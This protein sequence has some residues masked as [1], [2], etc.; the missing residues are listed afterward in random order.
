MNWTRIVFIFL[1]LAVVV[2]A[3]AFY[4]PVLTYLLLSVVFAYVF[5]PVVSW[6]ECKR[7]PR[8]AAALLVYILIG[9][10][11]AWSTARFVPRLI[12]EGNQFITLLNRSGQPLDET[13]LQLP[14]IRSA[15]DFLVNLDAK[16]PNINL[17]DKLLNLVSSFR[18]RLGELPQLLFQNYQTILST[19]ALVFTIPIF[20]FFIL[21]D[22]PKLR[23]A[24]V[25]LAPNKYFELTLILL[26]K[27]DENV[28]RYLRAML[29]EMI[30]VSIMSSIALTIVGVPYSVLIG[31]MAGVTNIIPYVGPWIGGAVGAL[32]ILVTGQ[33]PVMIL[34]VALA[35]FL[36]QALDNYV[37]YPVVV[38][39]TIKMHP[40]VVLVTV[41]AG[42][43]FGGVVWMLISVPLVFMVYSLISSL[44]KNLKQ[45]RLL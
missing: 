24:I 22:K 25:S 35:M 32:T 20:S 44:Q 30:S 16:I 37:L 4:G 18:T 8:W 7:F 12:Q 34:W 14:F 15:Y 39:K 40:L 45:F 43:Y 10:A 41:F 31:I 5:D 26:N 23:K 42:G 1:M 28:G 9:A 27:I 6:L 11:I 33:P 13:I 2:G 36:V 19:V 29:L 17:A 38:G 3:F 21:A